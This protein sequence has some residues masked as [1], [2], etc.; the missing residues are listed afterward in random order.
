MFDSLNVHFQSVIN[1]ITNGRLVP[2]FGAGVNLVG[3][4][5]EELW[6]AGGQYLPSG[7]ELSKYL[8]DAHKYPD[9]DKADLLRVSQYIS[10][11]VGT[12]PLYEELHELFDEDYPPNALHHFFARLP[13]ALRNKGYSFPYQFIVTTNYDDVM[14]RA[15]REANEPYDL[16]TFIASGEDRGK[17]M[18]FAPDKEGVLIEKPNE[19]PALKLDKRSV[20]LKIHG[21][22]DRQDNEN[23]SYVITEDDYIDYLT[24]TE[25]SSFVPVNLAQKLKKNH[26]LFLGYGLRDW[27]LR[28]ILHR[29]W[30]NRKRSYKSW[31]IQLKPSDIEKQFWLKRDVDIIDM[32]LDEYI[33][34]LDKQIQTLSPSEG[35]S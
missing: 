32:G 14:E 28:V 3:R 1:G 30:G 21:A 4:P 31:A 2:F 20:I 22:V 12:G 35:A 15:F 19:Y 29:I 6:K 34:E 24:R 16:V 26:F 13:A 27:N 9:P 5:D 7:G 23:D 10:V 8:A 11:M 25:I 18:H 33:A 17:F